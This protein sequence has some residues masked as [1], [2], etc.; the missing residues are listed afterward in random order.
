MTVNNYKLYIEF[1]IWV[2]FKKEKYKY[3]MV[4]CYFFKENWRFRFLR[5]DNFCG[6]F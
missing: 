2:D 5:V 1:G 3:F 4:F 6:I